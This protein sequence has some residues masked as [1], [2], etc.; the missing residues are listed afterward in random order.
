MK[1]LTM[2]PCTSGVNGDQHSST[3]GGN[4]GQ[5]SF[6][7]RV[8]RCCCNGAISSDEPLA[9]FDAQG[10]AKQHDEKPAHDELPMSLDAPSF[11]AQRVVPLQFRHGRRQAV[12]ATAEDE[13]LDCWQER[14]V[15]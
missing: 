11:Q 2:K 6:D 8:N 3:S 14:K 13:E 1:K 12:V 5:H 7:E 15:E 4:Y 10:D 9:C